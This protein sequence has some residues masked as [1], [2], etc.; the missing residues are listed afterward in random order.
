[1]Q[2]LYN[3]DNFAVVQFDV[4]VRPM[5]RAKQPPARLP[6]CRGG[7]EIVDKFARKE[8][9]LDGAMAESFKEGVEALI[10]TSPGRGGRRLHRPLRLPG[11]AAG[12]PALTPASQRRARNG[13]RRPAGHSRR[14]HPPPVR[15][16]PRPAARSSHAA[17]AAP[18]GSQPPLF[19]EVP[20]A[21]SHADTRVLLSP[22]LHEAPV[23][24]RMC[25]QFV[26]TLTHASTPAASTC[27]ATGTACSR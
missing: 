19:K 4:P 18:S 14:F 17:F 13:P 22:G 16:G 6:R 10:E 20:M 11:A 1:M 5:P 9:F 3:S 23:L 8:I 7:Y 27:G 21:R 25:S 15:P 26:L 24:D 2:M 12:H